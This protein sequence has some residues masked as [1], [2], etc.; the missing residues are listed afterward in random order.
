MKRYEAS[1]IVFLF[2]RHPPRLA[3]NDHD[4]EYLPLLP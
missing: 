1:K 3:R 2:K 4:P